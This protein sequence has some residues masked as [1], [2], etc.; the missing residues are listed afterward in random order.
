MVVTLDSPH[1][2]YWEQSAE[3]TKKDEGK[4]ATCM[5]MADNVQTPSFSEKPTM[6]LGSLAK[7]FSGRPNSPA[8]CY[9][10][11]PG[12]LSQNPEQLEVRRAEWKFFGVE[13]AE[14]NTM[15]IGATP[16]R[17]KKER[18]IKKRVGRDNYE[19]DFMQII[20]LVV[21]ELECNGKVAW[22]KLHQYT[23]QGLENEIKN[24]NLDRSVCDALIDGVPKDWMIPPTEAK[25][26]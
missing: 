26:E 13:I 22:Q 12:K 7:K 23:I 16:L 17:S 5:R 20:R 10:S 24:G 21:D 14:D 18:I 6:S 9:P 2:I 19:A 4:G 8:P 11:S 1:N 25:E 15:Y 3:K